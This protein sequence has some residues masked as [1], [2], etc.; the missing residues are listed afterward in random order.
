M[1]PSDRIPGARGVG[2]KTAASLLAEHGTLEALLAA[3][4]FAAEAPALRDYR[5]IA[6]LDADRAAPTR[7]TTS[8][9]TG[10]RVPTAAR[11]LGLERLAARLE[12]AAE[13]ER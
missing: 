6:T 5:Q 1:I 11:E 8:S 7:S 3:G 13:N 2:E 10:P 4:R 9:R 12:E